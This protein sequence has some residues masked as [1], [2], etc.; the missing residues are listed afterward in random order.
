MIYLLSVKEVNAINKNTEIEIALSM[1]TNKVI[2]LIC[3]IDEEI[4]L[5]ERWIDEF[6]S[7]NI[8]LK[9]DRR[10]GFV[11]GLKHCKRLI[12]SNFKDLDLQIYK[13][14]KSGELDGKEKME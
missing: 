12:N 4:F 7:E 11:N 6:E 14:I 9:D 10:K 8:D 2:D 1:A 3:E 5:F 13:M